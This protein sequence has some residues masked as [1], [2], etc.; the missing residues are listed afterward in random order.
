[1]AV[2][3]GMSAEVKGR[4]FDLI[5]EKISI[6]RNATNLIVLEHPSVS[7]RHCAITHVNNRFILADMGSTNGTRVN[8]KDIKAEIELK[9]KDLV[10]IGALEF[11]FDN[12]TTNAVEPD[13]PLLKAEVEE[14]EGPATAPVSFESISPYG[15]RSQQNNALWVGLIVVVGLLALILVVTLFFILFRS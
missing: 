9:P 8:Q 12:E 10:Q 3:I 15:P 4:N 1:M 14:A 5:K 2:L 13:A 6:G 11:M 7:G